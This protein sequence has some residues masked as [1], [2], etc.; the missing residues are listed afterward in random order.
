LPLFDT[1]FV[2][3]L[4]KSDP[5]ALREAELTDA[6]NTPPMLSV[7]SF[8][9]YLVGVH[10]KFGTHSKEVLEEKLATAR[11]HISRF[12]VIPLTTGIAETS[13][14]LQAELLRLGKMIGTND[15]YIAATALKLELTLVTRNVAEFKQVPKLKVQSY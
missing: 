15:L 11:G 3:D 14:L 8:H 6:E 9:E 1:T 13:S 12:D 4:A 7:L 5:G 10:R 2:V